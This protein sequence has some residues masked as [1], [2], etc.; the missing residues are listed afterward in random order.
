MAPLELSRRELIAG[1]LGA[2]VAQQ[3]CT[4]S[5]RGDRRIPGALVDGSVATGHLLRAAQPLPPATT[6]APLE[7]AIVGGG[8]AGLSAGW[9]LAAAGL[10]AFTVL[11]LEEA[12]GGTSR[13]GRNEVSAFPWGAHYLPA[14]L[15]DV[16][17]TPRLLR[18]LGVL[19]TAADGELAYAEEALLAEPQERVFHQGHWYEG[20]YLRAG[21]SAAD[22]EQLDRFQARMDAFSRLRDGKGRKA[23]AVPSARC[24]DDAD[25]TALDRLSMAQ[26]LADHRFDSPRLRWL[27]DYACR[28][29]F[30]AR[31]KHISAWAAIWYFAARSEGPDRPAA[32]YLTW[33]EGNGRLVRHLAE[34]I[35]ARRLRTGLLV[36]TVTPHGDGWRL[37]AVEARTGAPVG[38]EARQVVF[39]APRFVAARVLTPW[40][41]DPP[42]SVAAFRYSPWVV[43]NL[44]LRAPPSG[45]GAP[46]SW[47]NVLY[48]SESLGYVVATHQEL[49][50]DD[51]GPTVLTWYYPLVDADP[52]RARERLLSQDFAGWE[53]IIRTDLSLP[54]PDLA[55]LAT[56]L[57]VHR[58]GH[59]MIRPTP[60]FIWGQARAE[61]QQSL[62][63]SLHFAHSELGGMAL[64][65]EASWFGVRAAERALDGLGRRATSWL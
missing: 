21:A 46:L 7:V 14:P 50:A 5:C 8:V 37:H 61:A 56:R 45:R 55:A 58:W 32:G 49:R 13:A 9:R 12:A 47:D 18:E 38:F 29:D 19:T 1:F 24:S 60:G 11:E 36:H 64:F 33:P 53:E 23:F 28:D 10:D 42:P 25:L 26:W 43:A 34:A 6:F 35:T 27:V 41:T 44:T 51:R 62:R 22:L 17:P 48:D 15:D 30:G 57:E 39:A 20:L 59:A 2:A 65:E 4:S 52:R 31:A 3:A 16:G 63:R 54:H 40:R